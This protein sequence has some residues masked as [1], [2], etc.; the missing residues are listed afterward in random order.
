[1]QPKAAGILSVML[2]LAHRKGHGIKP[3]EARNACD[4][5]AS[6]ERQSTVPDSY[7]SS[8]SFRG[9]Q[10][11]WPKRRKRSPERDCIKPMCQCASRGIRASN[12]HPF[13][14]FLSRFCHPLIAFPCQEVQLN[15][16][17]PSHI[18]IRSTFSPSTFLYLTSLEMP[19][20][21]TTPV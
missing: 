21:S 2:S 4:A 8:H 6:S 20:V 5:E 1:M 12:F 9:E 18:R 13:G 16:G 19:R 17:F 10:K 7:K 14:A 3:K 15:P 11:E